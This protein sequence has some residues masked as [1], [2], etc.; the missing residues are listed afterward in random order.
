MQEPHEE[1][2][3]VAMSRYRHKMHIFDFHSFGL[4]S[5]QK[6]TIALVIRHMFVNIDSRYDYFRAFVG[7]NVLSKQN[8][9]L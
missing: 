2:E 7:Q 4:P 6:D 1:T 8:N 5:Q 3:Y 9:G